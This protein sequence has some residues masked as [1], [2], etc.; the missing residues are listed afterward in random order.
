MK[1]KTI[2]SLLCLLVLSLASNVYA[3]TQNS[4][5]EVIPFKLVD[6]KIIIAATINDETADF[7]LDL[8]SQNALI[9]EAIN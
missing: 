3:Q 1:L 2:K 8:A 5:T 4:M 6:G 9:P 7:V